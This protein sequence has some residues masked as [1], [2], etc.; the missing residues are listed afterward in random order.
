MP[1]RRALTLFYVG[2][3]VVWMAVIFFMSTDVGSGQNSAGMLTWILERL[4]PSY[5]ASLTDYHLAGLN[6]A[7]RKFGH[8]SEY[9]VLTLL[10][11]RA[12]Q[13][14]RPGL[15]WQ[16][17]VGALVLSAGFA[18]T[19]EIHQAFT[20]SRG[21]SPRD[22]LIDCAG[23]TLCMAGILLWFGVKRLERRLWMPMSPQEVRAN[24]DEAQVA[25]AQMPS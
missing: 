8:L 2:P 7:L 4:A 17:F 23:A 3:L 6:Y 22:V 25:S 20:A 14:G 10:A 18:A 24:G 12:I 21:P 1:S 11:V 19:D 9:A 16:A 15:K 13:F 5:R